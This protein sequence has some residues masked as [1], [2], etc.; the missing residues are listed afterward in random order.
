MTR[1]WVL[2]D[3]FTHC[4]HCPGWQ[5]QCSSLEEKATKEQR[6]QEAKHAAI[7]A[8]SD[9][10]DRMLGEHPDERDSIVAAIRHTAEANGGRVDANLVR[11]HL[12]E[13]TTP[14]MVGA[15]FSKL[16]QQ[17][18]L[19]RVDFTVNTDRNGRNAGRPLQVWQWVE[20]ER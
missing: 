8:V 14:Q 10:T 13:G 2:E 20:A 6:H 18:R 16:A 17:G 5:I 1:P 9:I 19:V 15:V 11:P 7:V 3:L 4:D 12:P